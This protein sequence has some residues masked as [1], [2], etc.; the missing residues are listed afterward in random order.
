MSQSAPG[1]KARRNKGDS[2]YYPEVSIPARPA[3]QTQLVV[4]ARLM[5]GFNPRPVRRPD[6]TGCSLLTLSGFNPR[7]VRRP[8]ATCMRR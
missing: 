7:P 6:A 1:P 2:R 4:S 3:G 8:D 5:V